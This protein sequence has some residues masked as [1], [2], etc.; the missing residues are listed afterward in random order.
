MRPKSQG[1]LQ[2]RLLLQALSDSVKKLN[3]VSLMKNPVMFVTEM[4]AAI[5]TAAILAKKAGESTGFIIQISLWLWFTVLFAEFA[6]ALAEGRGKAQA[7]SLRKTRT[8]TRAN[9]LTGSND[10]EQ[11]LAEDLRKHDIV[12]VA[13]GETIPADGE[14]IEGIA[15][16]DESA[17]TGES[18][19]VIRESGGDRSAVTGGTRVLSDQIRMRVTANPGESFLDRMI[20]LVEGASRQKTP[21][22]IALTI[23]LS[24]LSVI[25]LVVVITLKFLGQYDR[26][27]VQHHRPGVAP[28]LSAAN[29]HR[30]LA[31]RHRHRRDR[32][33]GAEKRSGHERQGR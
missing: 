2:K 23:L 20:A 12:V 32:P 1:I 15:T 19:P 7:D 14:V 29:D 16:V 9:R 30:R 27:D 24:A 21:N 28:G 18:A 17:I 25:F 33:A 26:A 3:P 13:A 11:V 10:M 6:E 22:E 8:S 5:T 4:C 31:E